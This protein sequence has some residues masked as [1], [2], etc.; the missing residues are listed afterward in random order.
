MCVL[1]S[2]YKHNLLPSLINKRLTHPSLETQA[3]EA[4]S[5]ARR[6]REQQQQQQQQLQGGGDP[7]LP[8]TSHQNGSAPGLLAA[9]PG[10]TGMMGLLMGE[11]AAQP[12]QQA[13]LPAARI[14][15]GPAG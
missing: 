13:A 8:F 7:S 9:T 2:F 12:A 10:T 6:G 1:L 4:Q 11:G 5:A 14:H 15:L 3:V